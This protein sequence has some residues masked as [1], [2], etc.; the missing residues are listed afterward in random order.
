MTHVFIA[1]VHHTGTNFCTKLFKDIGYEQSDKTPKEAGNS[2]NYFHRAHIA[3]SV[4]TELKTWLDL[5]LPIVVPLRHPVATLKSWLSRGKD[6][7]ELKR[8]LDLLIGLVDTYKP[9]YLPIDSPDRD[10]YFTDLRLKVDLRLNTSWPVVASKAKGS[11]HRA[12]LEPVS[13]TPE[14]LENIMPY[15][16]HPFFERFYGVEKVFPK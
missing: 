10:A 14:G 6:P 4:A 16:F 8:Q 12:Q 11:D 1:S 9:L 7:A 15:C 5:G 13:P 3:D 2:A